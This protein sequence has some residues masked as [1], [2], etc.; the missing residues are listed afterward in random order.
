MTQIEEKRI[1]VHFSDS[2]I[3]ETIREQSQEEIIK[4]I[5]KEIE[6]TLVNH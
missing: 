5:K 6:T 2:M 3:A 4:R 1:I